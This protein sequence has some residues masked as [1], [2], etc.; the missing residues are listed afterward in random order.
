[1][2]EVLAPA[3]QHDL[4]VLGDEAG[5]LEPLRQVGGLVALVGLPLHA[6]AAPPEEGDLPR[7]PVVGLVAESLG[8]LD[9]G[10]VR[11]GVRGV[12]AVDRAVPVDDE[13][14]GGVAVAQAH[15]GM[16]EGTQL[17]GGHGPIR[18]HRDLPA[19]PLLHRRAAAGSPYSRAPGS[20][21]PR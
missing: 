12:G 11:R 8:A 9:H 5:P 10:P 19:H 16:E 20:E 7:D 4:V 13:A 2:D 18:V 14:R 6:L 17:V 3:E 21:E 15:L 1:M